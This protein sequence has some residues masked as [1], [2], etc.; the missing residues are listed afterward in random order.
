MYLDKVIS[1]IYQSGTPNTLFARKLVDMLSPK[2]FHPN[3]EINDF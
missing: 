1:G 3:V 2:T